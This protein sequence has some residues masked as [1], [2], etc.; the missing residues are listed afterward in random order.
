MRTY[1]R[2]EEQGD[3]CNS[4]QER[5]DTPAHEP[6]QLMRSRNERSSERERASCLRVVRNSKVVRRSHA[7][8]HRIELMSHGRSVVLG[9]QTGKKAATK[10]RNKYVMN[11]FRER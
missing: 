11:G 4:L 7:G 9:S 3:C 10:S 5:P 8:I 2:L 6:K 1:L